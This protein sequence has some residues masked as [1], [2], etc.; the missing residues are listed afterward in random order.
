MNLFCLPKPN[1]WVSH[2][3]DGTI[4]R[5]V[6]EFLGRQTSDPTESNIRRICQIE[7]LAIFYSVLV[8]NTDN[9]FVWRRKTSVVERMERALPPPSV[10]VIHLKSLSF[11][12]WSSRGGYESTILVVGDWML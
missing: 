6:P 9:R 7:P 2:F 8:R 4:C 3:M 11:R 12:S 5:V 1:C 10:L